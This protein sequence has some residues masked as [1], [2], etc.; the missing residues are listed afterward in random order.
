MPEHVMKRREFLSGGAALLAD[1]FLSV[2]GLC[3]AFAAD[4][5]DDPTS[6]RR[7]RISL[8]IDDIGFSIARAQQFLDLDLPITYSILPRLH[9]SQVLADEIHMQ[10][11]EIMLHQPMEPYDRSLNPGPGAL[12]VGDDERR[13]TRIMT[14]NLAEIPYAYGVNNHMGSRFTSSP[15]ETRDALEVLR[16]SGLFFVDSLTSQRSVVGETARRMKVP[17]AA[18]HIFL[19]HYPGEQQTLLAL[20]RLMICALRRG[21]AI[22]IGHPF[23]ETARAIGRF[24]RVLQESNVSLVYV[25]RLIAENY[26]STDSTYEHR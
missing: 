2:N 25:S 1:T 22:G 13:I 24:A 6:C 17:A 8:I 15:R 21:S 19:D 12:F 9:C 5:L 26:L 16:G 18:R 23:P 10:G 4:S 14:E 7:G 20:Q 3:S 11:H